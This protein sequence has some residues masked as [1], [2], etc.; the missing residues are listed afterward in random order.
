MASNVVLELKNLHKKYLGTDIP[1]MTDNVTVESLNSEDAD[2]AYFEALTEIA[3]SQNDVE[4][5]PYI[6]SLYSYFKEHP[7]TEAPDSFEEPE[8]A[9]EDLDKEIED[10]GSN[11]EEELGPNDQ[12]FANKYPEVDAEATLVK[13]YDNW[14]SSMK[15]KPFYKTLRT[16]YEYY[17]A[18]TLNFLDRE[19]LWGL[20]KAISSCITHLIIEGEQKEEAMTLVDKYYDSLVHCM[21]TTI[22]ATDKGDVVSSFQYMVDFLGIVDEYSTEDDS[23]DENKEVE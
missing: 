16:Y 21:N 18:N 20:I 17:L 8:E 23:E 7:V 14:L 5:Q 22:H 3:E 13:S 19:F 4:A 12:T 15:I 6:N 10:D 11:G 9:P 2:I 1:S